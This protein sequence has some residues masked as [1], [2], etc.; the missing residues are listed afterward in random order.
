MSKGSKSR[1]TD[2]KRFDEN[3]DKIEWN[4]IEVKTGRISRF[5]RGV[6]FEGHDPDFPPNKATRVQTPFG[7]GIVVEPKE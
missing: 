5:T 6:S 4:S 7:P 3:F 2:K 1:V